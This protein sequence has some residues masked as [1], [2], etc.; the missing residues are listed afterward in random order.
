MS[1]ETEIRDTIQ[2]YFDCMYESS[3][4]K[5]HAAFHP[6]ARITGYLNGKLEQMT[7]DAFAALARTKCRPVSATAIT[8]L[9]PVTSLDCAPLKL[10]SFP[11][12]S[13][14]VMA[15]VTAGRLPGKPAMWRCAS[16]ANAT[17]ST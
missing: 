14:Y 5:T 3:A 6:N 2:T 17:A 15:P 8:A 10:R 7:V 12:S 13:V 9:V 4:E 1:T 16:Q 11:H